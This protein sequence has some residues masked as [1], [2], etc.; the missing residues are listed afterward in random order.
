MELEPVLT[1]NKRSQ[2]KPHITYSETLDLV[3]LVAFFEAFFKQLH[4]LE[5][6]NIR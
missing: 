2:L 1:T 3:I 6:Q 4:R 5:E